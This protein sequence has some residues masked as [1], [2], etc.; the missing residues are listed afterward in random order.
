M[1]GQ[2]KYSKVGSL[3]QVWNLRLDKKHEI[4][5]SGFN[6]EYAKWLIYL[7]Y[8]KCIY[9]TINFNYKFS[10]VF[11]RKKISTIISFWKLICTL[12]LPVY[13]SNKSFW[14]L[15]ISSYWQS[16]RRLFKGFSEKSK[17]SHSNQWKDVTLSIISINLPS[18]NFSHL[19][20]W[21]IS[22][23]NKTHGWYLY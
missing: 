7:F 16:I 9:S 22:L 23:I 18:K 11:V 4:V 20:C 10:S 5:F 12:F 13:S 3:V 19:C 2:C 8:N 6:F 15:R 14:L 1:L 17:P 21:V